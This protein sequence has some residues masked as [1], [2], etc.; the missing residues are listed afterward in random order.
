MPEDA[1]PVFPNAATDNRR[2][3]QTVRELI[4]LLAQKVAKQIAQPRPSE[5]AKP[6]EDRTRH[7]PMP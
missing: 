4:H 2:I 7:Q 1:G 5:T 3:H 6:A